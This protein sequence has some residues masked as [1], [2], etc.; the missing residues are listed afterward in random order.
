MEI[1]TV[2]SNRFEVEGVL[3]RGGFA[4]AYLAHDLARSDDATIKELA[5]AGSTRAADGVLTLNDA[6]PHRLRDRFLD[7]ARTL[8][9]LDIPGVL[10]VRAAFIENGTAYF[11]T[12]CIPGARTLQEVLGAEGPMDVD[13][14][15]DIF[16]QLLETLE[17]LHAKRILHRD[18][19]P[20]NIL[21]SPEGQAYLIDFGAAREW[22]AEVSQRQTIL[23]TPGY[24]PLEQLAERAARGP[25]TDLYALSATLYHMLAGEPPAPS[26]DRAAGEELASLSILRSGIEPSVERAVEAGLAL[27]FGERPQ[28]AAALRDLFSAAAGPRPEMSLAE[29]DSE[30]DRLQRFKFD[31]HGCPA[32]GEP[33]VEPKPLR[34]GAC[35]VCRAGYIKKR[36]LSER[37]CPVC[38]YGVLHRHPNAGPLWAC[39]VCRFG[40]LY[41]KKKGL[42]KRG[43]TL[44]CKNCQAEF[45]SDGS[46]MAP[47]GRPEEA[48]PWSEWRTKSDRSEEIWACDACPAQLDS[49]PDGRRQLVTEAKG[50]KHVCLYPEEWARVAAGLEPGAGNAVCNACEADFYVENT[51]LTLLGTEEDPY[52]FGERHLGRLLGAEEARWLAVGKESPRPGLVCIHCHTELDR[53]GDF[54]RLVQTSNSP[55]AR[56]EGEPFTMEDWHRLAQGLP[57]KSDQA[58]FEAGLEEAIVDAYIRGEIGIETG[59]KAI[60]KG[61]AVSVADGQSA[62]LS[63]SDKEI[64]FGGL[65]RKNRIPLDAVIEANAVGDILELRLRGSDDP[66]EYEISPIELSVQLKSGAK[67][68][69][70]EASHLAERLKRS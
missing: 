65:L 70:L 15:L 47:L 27:K 53:E 60:W 64:V 14:A 17:A 45:D 55:L 33:M 5:P 44:K 50:M 28:S 21:I 11:A 51:N 7:E 24:A 31:R 30:L 42:L 54:L 67:T 4:I 3:G 16:F 10:P 58:N 34:S 37:Q 43:L 63:I 9:R 18:I 6:D 23:F 35:P 1:G 52:Q 20:S 29:Y 68:A 66:D 38:R 12:D 26:S 57:V 41:A 19:K 25:A 39:P 2:L 69:R 48:L 56:Y 49:M 62:T 8:A 32:C 40:Q 13:G 46:M 59:T 36:E 22:L 61:P